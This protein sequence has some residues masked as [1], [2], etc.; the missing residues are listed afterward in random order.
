MKKI[1]LYALLLML[2][3]SF[4]FCRN[5]AKKDSTDVA[6]ESNE[7]KK[8]NTESQSDFLVDAASSG[9][10]EVELGKLAQERAFNSRVKAFGKMLVKDHQDG[11]QEIKDLASKKQITLPGSVDADQQ[12]EINDLRKLNGKHFD[13]RYM[14]LMEDDH[15]KDIRKFEN[16]SEN[17]DDSDIQT[18]AAQTLPK[19]RAHLDS[20][21]MIRTVL[22]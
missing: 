5:G 11:N 20:V 19:L 21:K 18:L 4:S 10:M 1:S 15:E 16:A 2:S 6:K 14:Q 3:V 7:Q 12:R 17:H 9:L 13:E 8:L 22:K